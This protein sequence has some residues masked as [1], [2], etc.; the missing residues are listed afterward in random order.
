MAGTGIRAAASLLLLAAGAAA[1]Q[2]AGT[3][4]VSDPAGDTLGLGPEAPDVVRFSGRHDGATLTLR[5]DFDAPAPVPAG[6]IELDS[7]RDAGTGAISDIAFLCPG[8][9]GLGAD[10]TVDLFR[11]DAGVAPVRD[12]TSGIVGQ[13]AYEAGSDWIEIGIPLQLIGGNGI[14]HAAAILG[15]ESEAT[16]CVP[17]GAYLLTSEQQQ[18]LRPIPTAGFWTLVLLG[19]VLAMSAGRRVRRP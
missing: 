4:S 12:A 11:A 16:D 7:D 6:L 13:A 18:Q 14:V 1:G 2:V 15:S 8:F 17:D 19:L 5:L 9:V 3:G 10:Y